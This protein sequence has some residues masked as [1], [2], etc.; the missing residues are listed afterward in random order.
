M[1]HLRCHSGVRPQAANPETMNT[2]GTTIGHGPWSWIPGLP[3][4]GIPE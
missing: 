2:G 3:L 1:M 4:R